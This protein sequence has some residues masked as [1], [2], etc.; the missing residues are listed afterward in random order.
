[1][2]VDTYVVHC[3]MG[4]LRIAFSEDGTKQVDASEAA[5]TYMEMAMLGHYTPEGF[6]LTFTT[7]TPDALMEIHGDQI[8][9]LPPYSEIERKAI[10]QG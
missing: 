4:T 9:I 2:Q 8:T 10:S 3:P 7:L 5:R 6:G 1:M